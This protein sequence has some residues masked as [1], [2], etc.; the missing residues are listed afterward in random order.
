MTVH[1]LSI[2][3]R[4]LTAYV[5]TFFL[6]NLRS[7]A[8]GGDIIRVT[9]SSMAET[10]NNSRRRHADAHAVEDKQ[11]DEGLERPTCSV[12]GF[13]NAKHSSSHMTQIGLP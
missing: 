3:R 9:N 11:V 6:Y 10:L 5:G 12:R 2:F 1:L 8:Y 4:R 13:E 7:D